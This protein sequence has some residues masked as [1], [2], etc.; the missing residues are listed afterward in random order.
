[1][2]RA[3]AQSRPLRGPPQ[4]ISRTRDAVAVRPAAKTR[5]STTGCARCPA[6]QHAATSTRPANAPNMAAKTSSAVCIP[7]PPPPL[8]TPS[9]V[10]RWKRRRGAR[11]R[12]RH[13]AAARVPRTLSRSA[14][15]RV[16]LGLWLVIYRVVLID[17]LGVSRGTRPLRRLI[18]LVF[19]IAACRVIV[20]AW[21]PY[22]PPRRCRHVVPPAAA[23]RRTHRDLD[24]HVRRE[25]LVREVGDGLDVQHDAGLALVGQ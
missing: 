1:M 12:R 22:H 4:A 21:V 11:W 9:C 15:V 8:S 14:R 23:A 5:S 13:G 24:G 25:Q 10:R 16:S 6:L 20:Y 7:P 18:R 17:E 2:R 19:V 3:C